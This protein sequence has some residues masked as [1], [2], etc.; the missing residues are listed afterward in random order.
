MFVDKCLVKR[1]GCR[2]SK[3]VLDGYKSLMNDSIYV[4]YLENSLTL[5]HIMTHIMTQ[6]PSIHRTK[7]NEMKILKSWVILSTWIG[8]FCLILNIMMI[9]NDIQADRFCLKLPLRFFLF[10]YFFLFFPDLPTRFFCL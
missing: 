2:N 10:W 5:F 8:S 7:Q 3:E 6:D 1:D 4:I 9:S